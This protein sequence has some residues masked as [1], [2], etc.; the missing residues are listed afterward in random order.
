M[1]ISF[2]EGERIVE[3]KVNPADI[4]QLEVGR[5]ETSTHKKAS[6]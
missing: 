3:I 2:T 6:T 1:Q 5:S 4:G